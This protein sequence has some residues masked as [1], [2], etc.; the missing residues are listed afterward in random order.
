MWWERGPFLKRCV[1]SIYSC[2]ARERLNGKSVKLKGVAGEER[3][4]AS[5]LY[6]D[7]DKLV[8][9]Q[10]LNAASHNCGDTGAC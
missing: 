6:Y 7:G 9:R 8:A 4:R 10:A 3:H 2:D 5:C 1:D